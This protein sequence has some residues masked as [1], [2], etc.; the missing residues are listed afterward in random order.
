MPCS[1]RSTTMITCPYPYLIRTHAHSC[2]CRATNGHEHIYILHV[3]VSDSLCVCKCGRHSTF[4]ENTHSNVCAHK[5]TERGTSVYRCIVLAVVLFQCMWNVKCQIG[6][7]LTFHTIICK[8][9]IEKNSALRW[10]YGFPCEKR[11]K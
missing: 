7:L 2:T 9:S 8:L 11:Q 6:L 5:H 1:S 4:T 10:W 3:I